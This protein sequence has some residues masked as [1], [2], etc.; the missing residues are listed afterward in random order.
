MTVWAM[1]VDAPAEDVLGYIPSFLSEDDP[2]PA[3]EQFDEHYIGGWHP[4]DGFTMKG[5]YLLFPGDPPLEP[6][7]FTMFGEEAIIM[8]PHSY[9]AIVQPDSSFQ[10]ARMD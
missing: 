3:R 6:L 2:R 7:A 5:K 1:L 9:V 10:V 8:Y 4:Q